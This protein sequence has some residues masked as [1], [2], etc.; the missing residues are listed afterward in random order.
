MKKTAGII[1]KIILG[2]VLLILV[3]LFTVPIIFKK[4]NQDKG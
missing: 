2:L 1:I 3:L 4:A